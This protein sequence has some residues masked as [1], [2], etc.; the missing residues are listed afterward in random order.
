M[1]IKLSKIQQLLKVN[2]KIRFEDIIKI[3][4]NFAVNSGLLK[5]KRTIETI[6]I[7]ENKQGNASMIML[8]NSVFSDK[9]FEGAARFR[10]SAKGAHLL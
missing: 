5:D 9:N 10:I 1:S 4:K 8:G 3:S 7:I 2:K 6:K